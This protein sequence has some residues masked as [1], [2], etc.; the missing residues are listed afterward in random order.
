MKRTIAPLPLSVILSMAGA[1]GGAT[2]AAGQTSGNEAPV[3]VSARTAQPAPPEDQMRK[4]NLLQRGPTIN[5]DFRGG[6][7]NEFLKAVRDAA[8]PSPVNIMT[9]SPA[10]EQ[11]ISEIQLKGVT[12]DTALKSVGRV[13]EARRWAVEVKSM[14]QAGDEV[15][16]FFVQAIPQFAQGSAQPPSA[17]RVSLRVFSVRDLL[18]A[19]AGMSGAGLSLPLAAFTSALSLLEEQS[20]VKEPR[21]DIRLHEASG[22]LLVRG[23]EVQIDQVQQLLTS[24][25]AEMSVRRQA[26]TV[27]YQE[28]AVRAAAADEAETKLRSMDAAKASLEREVVNMQQLALHLEQRVKEGSATQQELDLARTQAADAAARLSERRVER[29]RLTVELANVINQRSLRNTVGTEDAKLVIYD[30]KDLKSRI[31]EITD[32]LAVLRNLGGGELPRTQV[33]T[34]GSGKGGAGGPGESGAQNGGTGPEGSPNLIIVATVEQHAVIADV[35]KM[36]RG[37]K[38]ADVVEQKE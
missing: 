29:D 1:L 30:A 24:M 32:F 6:T 10:G 21:A 25:K 7:L 14:A 18:E 15:P 38:A 3:S 9:S 17:D 13:L 19:P 12:V 22:T 8:A 35:L 20:P 37:G 31:P 11:E 2:V 4:L 33:F 16:T 23:T 26:A 27:R 34:P 36:L 5:L 28:N